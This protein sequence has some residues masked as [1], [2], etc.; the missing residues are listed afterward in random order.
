VEAG[1]TVEKTAQG[2]LKV[3]GPDGRFAIVGSQPENNR[4][5]RGVV[6]AVKT[7]EQRTG[8]KLDLS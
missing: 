2:H 7:I 6:Q 4:G 3:I 1:A 5:G 8:L